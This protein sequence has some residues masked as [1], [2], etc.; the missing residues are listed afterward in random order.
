M[1][2]CDMQVVYVICY[3]CYVYRWRFVLAA[4]LLLSACWDV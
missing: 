2:M 3:G 4:V 1:N